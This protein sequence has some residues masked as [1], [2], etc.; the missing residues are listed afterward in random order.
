VKGFGSS[1][2][3]CSL[4]ELAER[5]GCLLRGDPDVMIDSA[6]P[7]SGGPSSVGIAFGEGYAEALGK[8]Q[9]A[10]V[11]LHEQAAKLCPVAALIH[12][13]PHPTYARIAAWLH[14][15]P[16]LDAG[17]HPAAVVHAAASVDA[18][19]QINAFA[20]VG[21]GAVIGAR[22][23]VG[24]HAIVG[25]G[26]V[27]GADTR[28]LER[29]TVLSGSRIGSRCIVHPGAVIGSDGFGNA[30]ENGRWVKVPQLGR[31][32]IGDDVEIGAN[33]TIDCGALDDTVIEEGV[34]LDNQIQIAHNVTIG[35]HTA[36]AACTGI[37]GSVNIGR[38]CMI[39]GGAGITGPATITDD[40]VIGGFGQVGKSISKPGTYASG[41]PA[42]E[43]RVWRRIVGRIKRLDILAARVRRLEVASGVAAADQKDD[44]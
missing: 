30:R 26:V 34:R 1:R 38:R 33:T 7:L 3:N 29:A 42:E 4:G 43:G 25:D 2:R 21:A 37:A 19:A 20:F 18:S 9:L 28:L 41:I 11:V 36:I 15:P 27:L 14:P 23:Y 24:P 32:L 17:I 22:C 35:A 13:A 5:F 44:D 40:V 31:A 6:G 39:G 16:A 10:A 12:P 8:T